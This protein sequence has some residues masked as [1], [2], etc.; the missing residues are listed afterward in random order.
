V[1][2]SKCFLGN[3]TVQGSNLAGCGIF[4]AVQFYTGDQSAHVQELP[5][6]SLGVKPPGPCSD[7]TP[8]SAGLRMGKNYNSNSRLCFHRHVIG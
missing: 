5:N 8:S 7:H 4:R 1:S 3:K 2:Y 6:L